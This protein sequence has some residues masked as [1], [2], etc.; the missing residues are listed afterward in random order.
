MC[1]GNISGEP[2]SAQQQPA[3]R[4]PRAALPCAKSAR[5]LVL[6]DPMSGSQRAGT[7][8][9]LEAMLLSALRLYPIR[10]LFHPLL[11]PLFCHRHVWLL[12]LRGPGDLL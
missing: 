3:Q 4:V 10:L 12:L 1:G 6:W 2:T 5:T 9:Q 7:H 11:L 8:P